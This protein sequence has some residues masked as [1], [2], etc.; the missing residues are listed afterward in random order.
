M[1]CKIILFKSMKQPQDNHKLYLN[2]MKQKYICIKKFSSKILS[3]CNHRLGLTSAARRMYLE[4]GTLVLDV[5][6]LIR[7]VEENYKSEM[8]NILWSKKSEKSGTEEGSF[9]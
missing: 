2:Q 4:D 1:I 9:I 3:Q 8:I 5:D 6:D 7:Y